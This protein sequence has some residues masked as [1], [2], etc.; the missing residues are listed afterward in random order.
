MPRRAIGDRP[1]TPAER[2]AHQRAKLSEQQNRAR[3]AIERLVGAIDELNTAH[4]L[5]KQEAW[6]RVCL[7]AGI[8]KTLYSVR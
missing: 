7:W 5:A 3:E 6:K 1:L 2:Q 8:C 4:P